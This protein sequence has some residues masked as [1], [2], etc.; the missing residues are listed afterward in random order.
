MDWIE[1]LII[2]YYS[3]SLALNILKEG[4]LFFYSEIVEMVTLAPPGICVYVYL[5]L[6]VGMHVGLI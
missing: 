3:L 1:I 2:N 4:F 6:F 5:Y